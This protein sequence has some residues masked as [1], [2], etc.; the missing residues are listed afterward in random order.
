VQAEAATG[1]EDATNRGAHVLRRSGRSEVATRAKRG[2]GKCPSGAK[3]R[4][5]KR[6]KAKS[7]IWVRSIGGTSQRAEQGTEREAV[8]QAQYVKC[9]LTRRSS[10]SSNGMPPGPEARY[11][12]HCLPSGPG[13][14][15]LLS[16]L[17]RTLGCTKD[18]HPAFLRYGGSAIQNL[19]V[20]CS[21]TDQANLGQGRPRA[22]QS[23]G[24]RPQAAGMRGTKTLTSF[25]VRVTQR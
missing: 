16:P 6:P 19:N 20:A 4:A 24:E 9:S 23:R 10:G 3:L 12:V 13:G 1:R 22:G 7:Q 2:V 21:A 18:L 14:T 8:L 5:A 17:A 15:P 25:G 11:G